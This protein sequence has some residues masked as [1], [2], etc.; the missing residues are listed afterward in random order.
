MDINYLR[1]CYTSI[2]SLCSR[3][4][5]IIFNKYGIDFVQIDLN[6]YMYIENDVYH[7]VKV[8]NGQT[9]EY[10]KIYTY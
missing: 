10:K 1:G 7:I 5:F 9:F 3:K 6:L 2:Y 8:M 4:T